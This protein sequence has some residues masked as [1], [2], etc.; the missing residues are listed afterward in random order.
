MQLGVAA[1]LPNAQPVG[2]ERSNLLLVPFD[3]DDAHRG[4]AVMFFQGVPG[5]TNVR[6]PI[7]PGV[8]ERFV[9]GRKPLGKESSASAGTAGQFTLRS[10]RK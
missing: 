10:R 8:M 6:T 9:T 2:Y 5:V 4:I 3:R 1:R 7:V